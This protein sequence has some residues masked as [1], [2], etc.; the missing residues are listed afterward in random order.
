MSEQQPS[1][2]EDS[3]LVILVLAPVASIIFAL[4]SLFGG[5]AWRWLTLLASAFAGF[6][7]L[8]VGIVTLIMQLTRREL[9]MRNTLI[10]SSLY[11]LTWVVFIGSCVNGI[12]STID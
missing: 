9:M 11:F 6:L 4:L 3:R 10:F 2:Q 12:K 7:A 5:D 8:V 1:S